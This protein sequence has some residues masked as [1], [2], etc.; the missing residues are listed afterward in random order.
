[1]S[2]WEA[3]TTLVHEQA[4]GLLQ[5]SIGLMSEHIGSHYAHRMQLIHD[6]VIGIVMETEDAL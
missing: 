2:V 3:K 6:Y 5:F 4:N 1:L